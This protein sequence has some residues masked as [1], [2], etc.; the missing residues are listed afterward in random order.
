MTMARTRKTATRR[1]AT[2]HAAADP[3]RSP[4]G[5]RERDRGVARFIAL[6]QQARTAPALYPVGAA[7]RFRPEELMH[8]PVEIAAGV[9]E[10]QAQDAARSQDG[11]QQH[12]L[13]ALIEAS[14]VASLLDEDPQRLLTVQAAAA[15]KG[16]MLCV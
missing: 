6:A 5:Q 14:G 7:L 13:A 1:I 10:A 12:D 16:G 9:A 8:L 4:A 11:C 2:G 3:F 15:F